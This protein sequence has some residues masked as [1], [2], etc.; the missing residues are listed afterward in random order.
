MS[1]KPMPDNVADQLADARKVA[2]RWINM[3][4]EAD[5][6]L[7]NTGRR[8]KFIGHELRAVRLRGE[9][10]MQIIESIKREYPTR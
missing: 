10:A 4:R 9:M 5:L 2:I 1:M 8:D 6:H 3:Q 7:I